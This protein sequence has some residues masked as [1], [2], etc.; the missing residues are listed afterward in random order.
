MGL[1]GQGL[2]EWTRNL[3]HIQAGKRCPAQGKCCVTQPELASI[4]VLGQVSLSHKR[5]DEPGNRGLGQAATLYQ[6]V[7]AQELL[8]RSKTCQHIEASCERRDEMSVL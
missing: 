3:G 8:T 6:V 2:H 5:L 1:I 4:G 7:V